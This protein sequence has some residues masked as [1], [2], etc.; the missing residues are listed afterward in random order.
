[1]GTK[2]VRRVAALPG[3]LLAV[4]CSG[5]DPVDPGPTTVTLTADRTTA[6]TG[7]DIEFSFTANGSSITAL[8][9]DYGDGATESVEGFGALTMSGHRVHVYVE[10][11]SYTATATLEDAITGDVTDD[12][13]V[14]IMAAARLLESP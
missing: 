9:L 2:A 4:S 7:Q 10:P 12:L 8:H 11:G 3:L 13:T 5:L 6:A 1:M 14:Q